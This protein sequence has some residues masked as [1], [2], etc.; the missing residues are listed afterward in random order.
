MDGFW[1]TQAQ[2]LCLTFKR[3]EPSLFTS[4]SRIGDERLVLRNCADARTAGRK[5]FEAD[6]PF[7]RSWPPSKPLKLPALQTVPHEA[8]RPQAGTIRISDQVT[9]VAV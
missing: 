9:F 5:P 7:M 2:R 4:R 6:S 1:P 3:F 8:L